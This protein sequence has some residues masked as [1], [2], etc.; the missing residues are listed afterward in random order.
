[1][2]SAES[3]AGISFNTKPP[4]NESCCQWYSKFLIFLHLYSCFRTSTNASI[5]CAATIL[6][7]IQGPCEKNQLHFA[8]NTQLIETLNRIMRSKTLNDCV[9]EEETELKTTAIDIF[10][11][12]PQYEG[13]PYIVCYLIYVY[14]VS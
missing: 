12:R 2:L 8:L 14:T 10:Q 9:E 13:N 11:V 4:M 5:R 3:P 6:E 1:M 7:V